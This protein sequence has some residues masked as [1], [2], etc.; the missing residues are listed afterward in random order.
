MSGLIDIS[1]IGS[2]ASIV[3]EANL[4][5]ESDRVEAYLY[6][7][8]E[9]TFRPDAATD[10]I[11]VKPENTEQVSE[12]MK[13]A[14]ENSI[15]VVVRG[16]ATGLAGGCT[17]TE[18]GIIISMMRMNRILEID[19]ANMVAVMEAGVTLMDLLECLKEYRDLSF[20]V[21]P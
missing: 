6:D 18:K 11:V 5:A 19:E 9:L 3:G 1:L 21:H 10:C 12:I 17:P 14:S 2:L 4:V 7:E 20:P 8:V 15:P 16:G 13:L